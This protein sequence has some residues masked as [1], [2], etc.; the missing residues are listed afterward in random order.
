M[1][2]GS[3]ALED[4]PLFRALTSEEVA[5][6]QGRVHLRVFKPKASLLQ[7]GAA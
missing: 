5:R 1:Q 6:L 4:T 3:F 7:C 2:Q